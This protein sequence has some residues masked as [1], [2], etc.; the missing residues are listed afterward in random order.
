ME[1]NIVS[2]YI[3]GQDRTL[4]I[5][6]WDIWCGNQNKELMLT[7]TFH[8]GKKCSW[9]MT[10]C[11]IIPTETINEGLLTTTGKSVIRTPKKVQI[12][13]K[14]FAVAYYP[15]NNKPYI[16]NAKDIKLV[17][18]TTLKDDAV[19][20]YFATVSQ[21]RIEQA[22][23]ADKVIAENV[24]RQLNKITTHPDTALH[25]YCFCENQI[26]VPLQS[27]I[28]PFGV[29]ES[30][31]QAVE[32]AFSSQISIIE[33]PPGTGKTQT[34]LNIV[35]NILLNQKTV[36]ILSNNN[37]A[38]EN[39]Y[40]KLAKENLDY[41]VAKL[42]SKDNRNQF[43]ETKQNPIIE[44][45]MYT[46][47]ILKID[48][49]LNKLKVHLHAINQVALLKAQIDELL[50]EQQYLQE[51]Q[52]ENLI[53]TPQAFNKYK[54]SPQKITDLLA[55]L[56]YLAEK[57]ISF[58]DR[59]RLL[60]N[61]KIIRTSYMSDLEKR[62]EFIYALQHFYYEKT[63]HDKNQQLAAYQLELEQN[64]F[65][66]LLK[67]LTKASMMHFKDH[68][69]RH[70]D[71]QATFNTGD[72]LLYFD[73][74]TQRFPIIGSS[75]HSV[76]NSLAEG[77]LLDYVIIDEASQQD[78]IPGILGLGCAK[79]L[80]IVGDRKQLP[81]VPVEIQGQQPI[82]PPLEY[83]DSI[84][85]SL[86]DSFIKLFQNKIPITL[87]REHY[88]CHPKIIQFCNK[89]FYDNQLIPMTEDNG[90]QV[91]SLI[92]TAKGNHTRNFAN[93][94]E[95][96]SICE[97]Y[98]ENNKTIGF[99][100]P[101][102]NQV[103]LAQEYLSKEIIKATT[104]KFQG[105]ECDEIIFST[106]LDKK[107]ESQ[108]QISFVDDPHLIN[109]AVSRAKD[110]F[111]LTTGQEVFTKNNQSISALIRYIQYYADLTEIYDSPVISAFDLLY[112]EYDKSLEKLNAKLNP[113]DSKYKSE[114]I[115]AQLLREL[116]TQE[117]YK[118]IKFHMQIKLEQLVIQHVDIFSPREKEFMKNGASCDFVLYYKVG[119]APLGVIEVDGYQHNTAI[120]TERD[121]LKDAILEK[122]G[123]PLLRLKTTDS[124]IVNK[125]A[126]FLDQCIY[127]I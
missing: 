14:K 69:S 25:A 12:Y 92:N 65:E 16:T 13:G 66:Y 30:Q 20:K 59:V 1:K 78:I 17:P 94:R 107:N 32:K 47:D 125:I 72:Y 54:L 6:D 24:F 55:Y 79:N 43:F 57:R 75:T 123:I 49:K 86:L 50:I 101:Y 62:R 104:H 85:Y 117:T 83:Y 96:E 64:N 34:I 103:K 67:D 63:L 98:T 15:N 89:Q 88:R 93:Q 5:R 71:L 7:V 114:Q 48:D 8:S 3:D 105:R 44:Q 119:K 4:Q 118:S 9:S 73:K 68:L 102:N 23:G 87:L 28:Y 84:K 35:A 109:V 100:T 81:H 40:E 74:F 41:L 91:L 61:F 121:N 70:I 124:N 120:Q 22:K 18:E 27:F 82:K 80:I 11:E 31:L 10:Q 21:A 45:I 116:L 51:W 110:K 90:E 115:V 53:T 38:V 36:V 19:F 77:A 2:I 58:M 29:N 112:D 56:N 97:V 111:T 113:K 76:I 126:E 42:G 52:T 99:I 108:R 26:R 122:A 106:V 127:S 37:S 95:L 46:G 33:G 60:F 39:I